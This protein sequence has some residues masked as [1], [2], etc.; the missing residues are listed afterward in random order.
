MLRAAIPELAVTTDLMVGF[1]GEADADFEETLSLMQQ[2]RFD[3][4]FA[5]KFSPRPGTPAAGLADQVPEPVKARRLS[6]LLELQDQHSLELNQGMIGR[7]V[8][9]LVDRELS[10]R[11][12]GLAAGRTRQNKI[13]HFS[14]GEAAE[15]SLVTVEVTDATAHHLK[16]V[17]IA[18][19]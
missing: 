12:S 13:V 8:A 18:S 11:S 14:G 5:F 1:P 15:G 7:K 16:G 9:V 3:G 4:C 17:L 10:K 6:R 19:S 2:V